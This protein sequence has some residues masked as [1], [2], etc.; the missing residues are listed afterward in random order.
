MLYLVVVVPVAVVHVSTVTDGGAQ[1]LAPIPQPLPR[2]IE[3]RREPD[4][5]DDANKHQQNAFQ[6]ATPTA[7]T[8]SYKYN[9]C[10][11]LSV[12]VGVGFISMPLQH[13]T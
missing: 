8:A 2:F 3:G 11:R 10:D 6:D 5:A 12:V 7:S 4:G 9:G 1:S 13:W